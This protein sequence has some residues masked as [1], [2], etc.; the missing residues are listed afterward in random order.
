TVHPCTTTPAYAGMTSLKFTGNFPPKLMAL[1]AGSESIAARNCNF[2]Y[3]L[4]RNAS[5]PSSRFLPTS[6]WAI[7]S[8]PCR[9]RRSELVREEHDS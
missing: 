4:Q 7:N 9:R 8:D 2:P 1:G 6:M 5:A 3:H